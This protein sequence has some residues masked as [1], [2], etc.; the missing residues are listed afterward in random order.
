MLGRTSGSKSAG[1]EGAVLEESSSSAG[2]WL[3]GIPFPKLRNFEQRC[4]VHAYS[5][6]RRTVFHKANFQLNGIRLQS[7]Y[8]S[9]HC[10]VYGIDLCCINLWLVFHLLRYFDHVLR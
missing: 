3:P 6:V 7:E 8:A 2:D 5:K 4:P 9:V 10:S 1:G